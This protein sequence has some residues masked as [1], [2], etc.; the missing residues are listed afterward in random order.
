MLGRSGDVRALNVLVVAP[1]EGGTGVLSMTLV[2]SGT[3][4]ETLTG[5]TSS[6][7][8]VQI[9]GPGEIGPGESVRFGAGT[10]PAA[11]I[12]GLD[13][14]PGANLRLQ[15]SFDG[16]DPIR[17]SPPVVSASGPY[18]SLTPAAEPTPSPS[19]SASPQASPS[20]TG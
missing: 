15:L 7:G 20:P 14:A 16:T 13:A 5:I 11:T 6:A 10:V 8:E 19:G 12:S 1:T 2:N 3:T 18:A 9:T 17:L 4:T